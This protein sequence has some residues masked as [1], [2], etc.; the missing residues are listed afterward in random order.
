MIQLNNDKITL[1]E[2]ALALKLQI[3]KKFAKKFKSEEELGNFYSNCSWTITREQI[4]DINRSSCKTDALFNFYEDMLQ[5]HAPFTHFLLFGVNK[6]EEGEWDKSQCRWAPYG[7]QRV[8]VLAVN[9]RAVFD[10]SQIY[11][12]MY[13]ISEDWKDSPELKEF[14]EKYPNSVDS[15][16]NLTDPFYLGYLDILSE[17]LHLIEDKK[18]LA[19]NWFPR[20]T[21]S[22]QEERI[23]KLLD[24]KSKLKSYKK[25][26]KKKK[27]FKKAFKGGFGQ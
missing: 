9:G 5:K 6:I 14:I 16:G 13:A 11:Y 17:D 24:K 10:K 23:T 27:A 12:E 21:F 20:E 7:F 19:D 18:E 22:P 4:I 15:N 25:S 1:E 3:D 2:K 26:T 8:G